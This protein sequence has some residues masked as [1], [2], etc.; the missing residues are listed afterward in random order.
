M[1]EEPLR[2]Q[3]LPRGL[4]ERTAERAGREKQGAKI[5]IQTNNKNN[6]VLQK[7]QQHD[8]E[9]FYKQELLQR[10]QFFLPPF[11]R[12]IAVIVASQDKT[13]A[14]TIA[15]Q[16]KQKLLTSKK[17]ENSNIKILGPTES[18]LHFLKKSYRYRF[19]IISKKTQDVLT[20]LNKANLMGFNSK[21]VQVKIDVDLYSF[22]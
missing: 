3:F 10:K 13:K 2:Q 4:P 19:L 22:L 18:Q 20:Y 16:I 14:S 17:N 7:L 1:E 21:S 15:E 6:V 9:G 5:Y 11:S 12:F 8:L